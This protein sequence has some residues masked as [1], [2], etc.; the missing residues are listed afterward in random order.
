MQRDTALAMLLGPLCATGSIGASCRPADSYSNILA[1]FARTGVDPNASGSVW[2]TLSAIASQLQ[3]DVSGLAPNTTYQLAV[4]DNL[5]TRFST[6]D[7]GGALVVLRVAMAA[8]ASGA[9]GTKR[10][11]HVAL[12]PSALA[13]GGKANVVFRATSDGRRRLEVEAEHA[14]PGTYAVFVAGI[15][16][17]S[18]AAPAGFGNLEFGDDGAASP[19]LDFDPHGQTVE[20]EQHGVTVLS[21]SFGLTPGGSGPNCVGDRTVSALLNQG[22]DANAHAEARLRVR[23]DCRETFTVAIEDVAAGS[24]QVLVDGSVRATIVVGVTGRGEVELDSNDPPKPV[25]NF[26]PRGREIA[27]A[28]GGT[29]FFVRVFPN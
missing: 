4:D 18:L 14:P 2:T 23:D 19:P 27:I 7:K 5:K 9:P 6:D 24:Y 1:A 17:G 15:E 20:I 28:K 22:A 11:E 16:R 13:A 21:S 29:L 8:G 25:L 10:T 26:D 12:K 3:I